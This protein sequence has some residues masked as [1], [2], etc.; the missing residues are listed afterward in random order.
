MASLD[1]GGA[2]VLERGGNLHAILRDERGSHD[3]LSAAAG[4]VNGT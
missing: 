3:Y 1:A 2:F 4:P